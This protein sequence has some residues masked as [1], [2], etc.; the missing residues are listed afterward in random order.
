M[1]ALFVRAGFLAALSIV[2]GLVFNGIR[3]DGVSLGAA[4]PPAVCQVPSVTRPV[5]R[6]SPAQANQ[7]CANPN[8]LIADARPPESFAQGH[9]AG[10]VH[11]PC[12]A[13]SGVAQGVPGMLASRNTVVVY[14]ETTE[15]ALAVADGLMRQNTKPGLRIAVLEGGFAAWQLAGFACASGPCAECDDSQNLLWPGPSLSDAGSG[16]SP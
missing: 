13:P 4:P 3:P 14:G 7:L 1:V 5:E 11:L 12:A 10:A 8:V 9:V 2:A 15:E 16:V 6:L